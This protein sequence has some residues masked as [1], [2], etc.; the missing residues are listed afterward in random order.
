MNRSR[1]AAAKL[2]QI[3]PSAMCSLR[4]SNLRRFT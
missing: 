3:S 1:M 2:A 4:V